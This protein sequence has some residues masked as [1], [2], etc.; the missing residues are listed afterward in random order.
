MENL[1]SIDAYNELR[2][3]Q[4]ISE[5]IKTIERWK[6]YTRLF[7]LNL[8]LLPL[9]FISLVWTILYVSLICSLLAE[10]RKSSSSTPSYST[11]PL[12]IASC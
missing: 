11:G 4:N 5:W 9:S 3:A 7:G 12:G 10:R 2:P 8:Y 1:S 6:I